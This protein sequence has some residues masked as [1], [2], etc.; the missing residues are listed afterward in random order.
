MSM[1]Y[2]F[3]E[4]ADRWLDGVMLSALLSLDLRFVKK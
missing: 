2:G 1:L 3:E 4:P